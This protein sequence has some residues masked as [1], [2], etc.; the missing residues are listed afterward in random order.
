MIFSAECELGGYNYNKIYKI[1]LIVFIISLY[2]CCGQCEC[3]I[4]HGNP[5]IILH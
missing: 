1:K 2:V 3:Y 4:I 5:Y